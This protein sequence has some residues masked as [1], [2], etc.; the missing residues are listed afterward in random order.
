MLHCQ[1]VR[2]E[3]APVPTAAALRSVEPLRVVLAREFD[4]PP[5]VTDTGPSSITRRVKLGELHQY[6]SNCSRPSARSRSANGSQAS[7]LDVAM[8][9]SASRTPASMPRRPQT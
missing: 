6:V 2:D 9:F 5:P 8:P 1:A 7:P 4:D 3:P